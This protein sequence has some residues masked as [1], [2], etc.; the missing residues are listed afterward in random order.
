MPL[1]VMDDM[2]INYLSIEIESSNSELIPVENVMFSGPKNNLVMT[3]T[4]APDLYGVSS[5]T[6]R[7]SDSDNTTSKTF[8]FKVNQMDTDGDRCR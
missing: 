3:I 6:L 1:T 2:D 5:I 8:K 4:P 7:V